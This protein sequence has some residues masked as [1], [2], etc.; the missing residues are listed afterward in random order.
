MAKA[1]AKP[2]A[3][4]M[5]M[6]KSVAMC[7]YTGSSARDDRLAAKPASAMILTMGGRFTARTPSATIVS[8]PCSLGD[9]V[10]RHQVSQQP[11]EFLL[12]HHVGAVGRCMV[13]IGMGLDE[14]AGR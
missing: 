9:G 3:A 10:E 11:L 14:D 12:R 4:A 13:G 5:L 2:A 1:E 6:P 8:L 7:G